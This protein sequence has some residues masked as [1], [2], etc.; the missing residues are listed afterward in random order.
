M[1][2]EKIGLKTAST[3]VI[4]NMIGTGVF[5]SLGFQLLGITN[6]VSIAI[7]WLIGGL[8]ALCGAIVYSELGA[9]MPRSGGEYHY[10]SVIYH[11]LIG[12]LSGWASLIVGFAAPVALSSMALSSYM[13]NIFGWTDTRWC[14]LAVLTLIT[15]VHAYS[16]GIGTRMQNVLTWMKVA[17]IVVF[18]VCGLMVDAGGAANFSQPFDWSDLTSPAFAVSLVWVYYAYSGWNAAAYI[19]SDIDNPRR[20][21]PL[22]LILGT[23]A[24]IVMYLMLNMVFLR[25]TPAGEMAG[26]VEIGL[27]AARHIFGS[28]GGEVMGCLIAL[29]LMSSISAMVYVGPRVG[30]A[31]GEGHALFRFLTRKNA[32]GTPAVAVWTQWGVSTVMVMTD[33]FELVT[34]Y[35]G[36]ILSLC[37]LL[38]VGG[39]IV[40]RH[41]YPEADRPY[42][43]LFYPLPALL[44]CLVIAWS[45]IYLVYDDYE[46]T[47]VTGEQS[48]M[49]T[50]L[51]SLLTILVGCVLWWVSNRISPKMKNKIITLDK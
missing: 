10:L 7:L 20:N 36:I 21:V 23:A 27:I 34:Q 40:H 9:A 28:Q 11:P 19:A 46:K 16:T 6:P 43:S 22:A 15:M 4:A 8:T 33:S 32:N 44:F 50:S 49:W 39:V 3:F 35:T 12:F 31:M 37:A 18:I 25:T 29:M 1:T 24:V 14:A 17:I 5:T 48:V 45:I 2:T 26:Q 38:T 42:R 30:Q 13:G 47:F 51:M 41:R